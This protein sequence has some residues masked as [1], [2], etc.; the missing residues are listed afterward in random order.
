MTTFTYDGTRD[1]PNSVAAWSVT[2]W[3]E[4][5]ALDCNTDNASLGNNLGTLIKEL[6]Q[7]GILTGSVVS[8]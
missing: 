5:L 1:T 8:V 6:I 4:N 2:N 7:K 3:T